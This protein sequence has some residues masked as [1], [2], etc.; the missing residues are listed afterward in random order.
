MNLKLKLLKNLE[1]HTL[2]RENYDASKD[3][4]KGGATFMGRIL[5]DLG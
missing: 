2:F 5:H 3:Y 4:R 1:R